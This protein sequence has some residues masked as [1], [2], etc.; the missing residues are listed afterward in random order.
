MPCHCLV[1]SKCRIGHAVCALTFSKSHQRG[2]TLCRVSWALLWNAC[3][4]IRWCHWNPISSN[5]CQPVYHLNA[6]L[7]VVETQ[8]V[9]SPCIALSSLHLARAISFAIYINNL[10]NSAF[11]SSDLCNQRTQRVQSLPWASLGVTATKLEWPHVTAR[12]FG[13]ESPEHGVLVWPC[14]WVTERLGMSSNL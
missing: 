4:R 6:S 7:D 12:K 9:S 1:S 2:R 13:S 8:W 5:R 3:A 10:N 14:P 11:A